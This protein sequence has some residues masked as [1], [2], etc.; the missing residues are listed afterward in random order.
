MKEKRKKEKEKQDKKA[1]KQKRQQQKVADKERLV[2]ERL[3]KMKLEEKKQKEV[4]PSSSTC[5]SESTCTCP[6]CGLQY[7]DVSS[8]LWI[9]CDKCGLWLDAYCADITPEEIPD[10][11]ICENCLVI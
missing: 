11:F 10:E 3:E 9:K 4:S 1:D 8:L 6:F 2:Q 5:S 7:E